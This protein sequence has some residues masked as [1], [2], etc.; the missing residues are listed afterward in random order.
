VTPV[1]FGRRAQQHVREAAQAY[2]AARPGLGE[3]FE[4]ELEHVVSL[5]EGMPR[6]G[7]D[8]GEGLR[9]VPIRRFPYSVVY[10]LREDA[11][12]VVAVHHH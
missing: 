3:R 10:A 5:L 6:I 8:I 9:A 1:R 4:A 12:D 11:I 7:A 2:A